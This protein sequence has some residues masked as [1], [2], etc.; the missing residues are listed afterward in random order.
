LLLQPVELRLHDLAG[1]GLL[2]GGDLGRSGLLDGGLL[3][4]DGSLSAAVG[5]AAGLHINYAP[6]R[7]ESTAETRKP[8]E[9]AAARGKCPSEAGR[10]TRSA[11]AATP[12]QDECL[13]G[14]EEL[15]EVHDVP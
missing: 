6:P 2:I 12:R 13:A 5:S 8:A 1:S 3:D 7:P 15:H 14:V 9:L 11:W 10:L 4:G